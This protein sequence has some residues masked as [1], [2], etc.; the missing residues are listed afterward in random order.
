MVSTSPPPAGARECIS[1]SGDIIAIFFHCTANVLFFGCRSE[2]KDFYF[3]SE[4]K[5]MTKAG[6]LTLFT[7]FSRDQ[8]TRFDF[9]LPHFLVSYFLTILLTVPMNLCLS[10]GGDTFQSHLQFVKLGDSPCETDLFVNTGGK[11]LCAAACARERRSHLGPDRE[12][13][14]LFLHRRVRSSD[15]CWPHV[16]ECSL[17]AIYPYRNAKDMP[18]GVRDALKAGFQQEGGLSDEDAEMMLAA[19][20]KSGRFQSE[21]WS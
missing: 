15:F 9:A 2:S 10:G 20:E 3:R 18:N 11:A 13:R 19:M 17:T 8:V 5:E 7:A 12:S 21:T 16:H 4:W 1:L 6:R 14:S